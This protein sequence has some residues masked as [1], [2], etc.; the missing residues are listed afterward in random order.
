MNGL[1][2]SELSRLRFVVVSISYRVIR[3]ITRV[4]TASSDTRDT[5]IHSFFNAFTTHSFFI[6]HRAL[7]GTTYWT[8]MLYFSNV[9]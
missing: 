2:I 4:S 7:S 3:V 9:T 8:Y 5:L 1:I 6:L